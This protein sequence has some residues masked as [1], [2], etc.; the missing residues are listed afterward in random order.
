MRAAILILIIFGMTGA[1]YNYNPLTNP[2][3]EPGTYVAVT[4]TDSGSQELARY[5]GPQQSVHSETEQRCQG[6]QLY[7][8]H[9]R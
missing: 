8:N 9:Q 1:C 3:P 2:S 5:L 6:Q 4:L 7:R